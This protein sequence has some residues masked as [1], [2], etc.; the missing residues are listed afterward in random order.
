MNCIHGVIEYLE[1]PVLLLLLVLV[2]LQLHLVL[3]LEISEQ[4]FS[5]VYLGLQGCLLRHDLVLLFDV[6][7][8]FLY[9]NL[10]RLGGF[11]Q[12]LLFFFYSGQ[13]LFVSILVHLQLGDLV[14]QLLNQIKVSCRNL[15]VICLYIGVLLG[16]LVPQS[17]DLLFFLLLQILYGLHPVL[18]HLF[19]Q[20]LNLLV[21]LLLEVVDLQ[22]EILSQLSSFSVVLSL[23]CKFVVFVRKLLLLQIY[24]QGS[25]VRLQFSLLD[26]V[27]LLQLLECDL[28][29]FAQL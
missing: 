27:L 21:I 18:L 10:Q 17:L 14:S 2:A 23:Q 25:H 1:Q 11:D 9:L 24:V 5:L 22:L 16:V 7:L 19:P 3:V 15:R 6:L 29:I 26:P 13:Q 8:K 20:V 4:L 28:H 12:L